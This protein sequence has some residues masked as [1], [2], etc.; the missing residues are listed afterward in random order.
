M[1]IDDREAWRATRTDSGPATFRLVLDGDR[2]SVEAWGP[3]ADEAL[4]RAPGWAGHTDDDGG[5]R[6]HHTVIAELR[7]RLAGMRLTTTGR[8]VG[9]TR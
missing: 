4:E 1:R 9:S 6:A 8:P 5:F 2:L 3:G 7:R